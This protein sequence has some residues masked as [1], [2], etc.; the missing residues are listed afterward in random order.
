MF[1]HILEASES[2]KG[3]NRGPTPSEDSGMDSAPLLVLAPGGSPCCLARGMYHPHPSPPHI[4]FPSLCAASLCVSYRT[5]QLNNPGPSR[6]KILTQ[7]SY[8]C[9]GP[10]SKWDHILGSGCYDIHGHILWGHQT[11]GL[12][13]LLK[14]YIFN[15]RIITLKYCFG[16]RH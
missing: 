4:G 2:T 13:R 1:P 3:I 14:I 10:L 8:N 7:P 12:C 5:P 9:K 6:F 15:R 16:F 11:T